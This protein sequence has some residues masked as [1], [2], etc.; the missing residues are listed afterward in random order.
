MGSIHMELTAKGEALAAKIQ[1]GNGTVPLE[2]TRI[3]AASGRSPYPLGLGFLSD[4]DIRQT[5]RITRQESHGSRASVEGV[6]TNIGNASAGEPPLAAGYELFQLGMGAVDPDEG[7]ILYRISQFDK[8][9]WVPP[10]TEMGW[11][12]SLGWNFVVG[13]ATQVVVQIDPMGMATVRQLQ[14]H[15]DDTV[16]APGGVHGIRFRDRRLEVH[17]GNEWIVLLRH[18]NFRVAD[19]EL[20]HDLNFG[21]VEGNGDGTATLAFERGFA[22]TAGGAM[23]LD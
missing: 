18:G 23:I 3:V 15:I 14:A 12:I 19:G 16:L 17:D 22:N 11:T 5:V 21:S 7:E 9:A 2:I 8:S 20:S 6:L 4:L 1:K 13:N 10:A